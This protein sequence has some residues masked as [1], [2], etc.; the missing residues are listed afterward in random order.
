[1][2]FIKC[3]VVGDGAFGKTCMFISYAQNIFPMEYIPTVFDEY[4]K[5]DTSGQEAYDRLRPLPYPQRNVFLV[6]FSVVDPTSFKNIKEKWVPEI[7]HHC[8]PCMLQP[9]PSQILYL[10][11]GRNIRR[12]TQRR[13]NCTEEGDVGGTELH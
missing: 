13:K 12:H 8:P 6:C 2:K 7:L 9:K 3:V 11:Q 5:P 10:L 4:S 1:M